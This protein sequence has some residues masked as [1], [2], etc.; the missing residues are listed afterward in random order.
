MPFSS[1]W[2]PFQDGHLSERNTLTPKPSDAFWL[3]A[4]QRKHGGGW[5]KDR[6]GAAVC[7]LTE[8]SNDGA[9]V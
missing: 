9:I 6:G 4:R 1:P 5:G 7:V 2:V 3:D 8:H